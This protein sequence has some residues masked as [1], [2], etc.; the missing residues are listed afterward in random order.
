M[1]RATS[2]WSRSAEPA[3]C[4]QRDLARSLG[5][6]RVYVPRHPGLLSAWGVLC[7]GGHARR[8]SDAPA[9]GAADAPCWT[10]ASARSSG[11]CA[12]RS[13]ATAS[14]GRDLERLLDVRYAGQSYEVS[15]P[16]AAGWQRDFH[17][18]HRRLFGHAAP[19]RPLEV[20][21][22]RLRGRGDRLHLPR[23]RPSRAAAVRAARRRVYFAG[24]AWSAAVHRR[25]DLAV[26][27]RL[28]GP[29]VI[30]EYSATTLVPPGWRLT[31]DALGG[32][33]LEDRDA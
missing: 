22:L 13:P 2:C 15:V 19:D 14:P 17:A 23:D 20:V 5:M 24:R 16:Y 28:R 33:V 31:V 27:R 26:G 11:S 7:R 10:A 30:C 12:A 29:A 21:T 8:Q 9:R 25:E 6:R 18:R 3:A 4:T 32:L 1:I